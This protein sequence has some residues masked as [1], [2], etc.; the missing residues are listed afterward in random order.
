MK[1]CIHPTQAICLEECD[2]KHSGGIQGD[3]IELP[4]YDKGK[5]K[6]ES[7]LHGRNLE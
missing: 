2:A 5:S 4:G 7:A 6:R 3:S 1:E